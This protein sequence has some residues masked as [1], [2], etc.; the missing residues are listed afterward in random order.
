M[1]VVPL[2]VVDEESIAALDDI[3]SKLNK[4]REAGEIRALCVITV[5]K[6]GEWYQGH[7]NSTVGDESYMITLIQSR[8]MR[9]MNE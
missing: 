2:P 3:V 6:D 7:F 4:R 5:T 8:L 9:R 1:N